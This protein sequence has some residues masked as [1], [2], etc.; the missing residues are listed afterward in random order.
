MA[1]ISYAITVCNELE[2][3][4][5]LLPFLIKHKQIHDE[6]VILFDEKNG[7]REVLE[8]LLEFNKLPNVQTWRNFFENDFAAA[9]N[10]LNMYCKNE[11]IYQLDADEMIEEELIKNLSDIL[12]TNKHIDLF[13]I[14]RINIVNGI[15]ETHI[16]KW[17]W[18]VNEKGWINF[19][20]FQG[21]I[22][23]NK[24]GIHWVGK[25]HERIVGA[26]NYSSFPTEEVYCIKHIKNIDRQEK[27]NTYY[28]TL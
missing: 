10:R 18:N 23:R 20:D 15:T 5:K 28:N 21:R 14:P 22:Y 11:W 4:K 3:I 27:Q 7:S 26:E 12:D 13:F 25:V 6:I 8:Y 16:K 2:E 1:K 9:K 24:I 17:N 19:P